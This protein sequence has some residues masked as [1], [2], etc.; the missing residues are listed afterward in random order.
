MEMSF[1]VITWVVSIIVFIIV[2]YGFYTT[3]EN[4]IKSLLSFGNESTSSGDSIHQLNDVDKIYF[5][6]SFVSDVKRCSDSK[7]NECYCPLTN[8]IIPKTYSILL[9]NV[10]GRAA[11]LL[12]KDALISSCTIQ[13]LEPVSQNSFP[14]SFY[15]ENIR[16]KPSLD[17]YE[18]NGYTFNK[19]KLND[20]T[21]ATDILF[22]NNEIC[23]AKDIN[24]RN[25]IDFKNGILYKFNNNIIGMTRTQPNLRRCSFDLVTETSE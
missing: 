13:N 9:K 21:I 17:N 2:L 11:L 16:G 1:K 5:Y 4:P 18:E 25:Y 23:S 3:T 7:D 15:I 8:T 10:A 24:G 19:L 6:S 14:F 12:Y 22:Q 20:F